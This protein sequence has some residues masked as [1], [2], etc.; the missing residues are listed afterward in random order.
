AESGEGIRPAV[1][2]GLIAAYAILSAEGTYSVSKLS[3]YSQLL[4]SRLEGERSRL[5]AISKILPHTLKEFVGRALLRNRTFCRNV[6]MNRWFLR[7]AERRLEFG[8][9]PVPQELTA[10]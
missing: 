6:V 3:V 4:N 1:E 5:D 10:M 9:R 7:I 8:P 2:S